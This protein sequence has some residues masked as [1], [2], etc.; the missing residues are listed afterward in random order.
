MYDS[1]NPQLVQ[2]NSR[3]VTTCPECSIEI[4]FSWPPALKDVI[5]CIECDT[6][7]EVIQTYPLKLDWYFEEPFD[8]KDYEDSFDEYWDY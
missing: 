7:L 6:N 4:S 3:L 2:S 5:Y 1:S 8:E